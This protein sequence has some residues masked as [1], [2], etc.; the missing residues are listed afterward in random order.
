MARKLADFDCVGYVACSMGDKDLSVEVFACTNEE[1]YQFVIEIIGK[2]PGIKK[3]NTV[4]VPLKLKSIWY[5]PNADED[6]HNEHYH[7]T[8]Q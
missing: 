5:I 1:L 3:T 6:E 4:I 8:R 2:L 7:S